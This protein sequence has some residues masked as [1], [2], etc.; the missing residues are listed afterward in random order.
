MSHSKFNVSFPTPIPGVRGNTSLFF[1]TLLGLAYM[2][3]MVHKERT[4]HPSP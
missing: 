3:Y 2:V 1:F 4:T